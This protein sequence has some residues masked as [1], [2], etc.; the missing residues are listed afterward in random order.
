MK[1]F[2]N[3]INMLES[4]LNYSSLRQKTISQ[5]IANE[6]TPGYKAKDVSFK[7]ALK[8]ASQSISAYRTD[9]R[10]IEFQ[11]KPTANIGMIAKGNVAFNQNG[12]S[13]DIDN[14]MADL[15]A[16]Q[17][18]FNALSERINGKFTSL[19]NVIRGGK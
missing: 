13:V 6:S 11:S 19:Q 12:N 5:N 14:E 7:A 10:H 3:T 9:E 2:S 8:E 17:I 4:G 16:N 15:A 18:Y 1:L